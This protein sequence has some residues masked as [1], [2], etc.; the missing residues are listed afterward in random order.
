MEYTMKE[1]LIMVQEKAKEADLTFQDIED[2]CSSDVMA[3]YSFYLG[4]VL[5]F[6][7]GDK[8]IF[9][10]DKSRFSLTVIGIDFNNHFYIDDENG[11][12]SF[13]DENKWDKIEVSK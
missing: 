13:M 2:T 4:R 9:N 8:I 6:K 7:T 1:L 5:K 10:G 12:I 3:L 11:R